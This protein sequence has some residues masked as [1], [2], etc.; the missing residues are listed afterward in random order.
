VS[1][2]GWALVSTCPAPTWLRLTGAAEPTVLLP[3]AGRDGGALGGR[4]VRRMPW[5]AGHRSGVRYGRAW[6][7]GRPRGPDGCGSGRVRVLA[8]IALGG[9]ASSLRC[10]LRTGRGLRVSAATGSGRGPASAARVQRAT[11]GPPR[12]L[13]QAVAELLPDV[14]HGRPLQRQGFL[15]SDGPVRQQSGG[16]GF[17]LYRVRCLRQWV[18]APPLLLGGGFVPFGE[19]HEP[20][21]YPQIGACCRAGCGRWESS[22]RGETAGPRCPP[23]PRSGPRRSWWPTGSASARRRGQ[24]RERTRRTAPARDRAHSPAAR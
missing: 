24:R 3:R 17:A 7:S 6:V 12:L 15:D 2:P 5:V 16:T 22:V 18:G 14:G 1:A 13:V 21:L 8:D 23:Q 11:P 4:K 9:R 20:V 10:P 19:L